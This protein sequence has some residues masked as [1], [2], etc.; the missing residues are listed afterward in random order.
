M[1]TLLGE[2]LR[3]WLRWALASSFGIDLALQRSA[4]L[5]FSNRRRRF[6]LGLKRAL[7]IIAAVIHR[8]ATRVAPAVI[9]DQPA[10]RVTPAVNDRPTAAT[11]ERQENRAVSTASRAAAYGGWPRALFAGV[12]GIVIGAALMWAVLRPPQMSPMEA[13]FY[14]LCLSEKGDRTACDARM[15]IMRRQGAFK[16]PPT[17][18][19]LP[20]AEEFFGPAPKPR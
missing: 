2:L 12:I 3:N 11:Q 5:A 7:A 15:R 20:T 16:P 10:T 1:G 6:W 9:P 17:P 14:D 4:Y 8:P 19:T 13:F 18:A